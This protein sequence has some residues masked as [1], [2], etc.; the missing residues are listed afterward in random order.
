MVLAHLRSPGQRAI[1]WV[2][3]YIVGGALSTAAVR[4]SVCLFVLCP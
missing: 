2:L 1:K 3:L 4:S